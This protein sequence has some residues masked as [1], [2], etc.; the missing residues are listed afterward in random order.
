MLQGGGADMLALYVRSHCCASC[1]A[2][3]VSSLVRR[4]RAMNN[5]QLSAMD[6]SVRSTMKGA[7]KCDKHCELQNSVNRQ[8]LERI[9]CFWEIP[10]SMPPSVFML[11]CSSN[12]RSLR[13]CCWECLCI[14]M[15]GPLCFHPLEASNSQGFVAT[16]NFL[17]TFGVRLIVLVAFWA[18]LSIALALPSFQNMKLGW[19]TRW[20]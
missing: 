5:S 1:I 13:A 20:I 3:L 6:V 11:Y 7:A 8:G 15:C 18:L 12:C 4:P 16:S 9:L 19:Q 14:K 17:S 2:I 10:E